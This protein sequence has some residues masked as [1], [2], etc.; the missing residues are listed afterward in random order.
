MHF[1]VFK[2]HCDIYNM[3]KPLS[4]VAD[5]EFRKTSLSANVGR[6]VDTCWANDV[7][8]SKMAE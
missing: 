8:S 7:S 1:F 6:W 5:L 4:I 3:R 2:N